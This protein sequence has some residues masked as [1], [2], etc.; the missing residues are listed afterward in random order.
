MTSNLPKKTKFFPGFLP[1]KKRSNQKNK[2]TLYHKLEGFILTLTLHTFLIWPIFRGWAE[3]LENIS[4]FFGEIWRQKK[5]I[6]KSWLHLNRNCPVFKKVRSSLSGG[7]KCYVRIHQNAQINSVK[8]AQIPRI[9]NQH[10]AKY[11]SFRKLPQNK[12]TYS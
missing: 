5:D 12:T 10:S 7:K 9:N 11:P 8:F 1:F 2:S 6:L 4:L 3:I